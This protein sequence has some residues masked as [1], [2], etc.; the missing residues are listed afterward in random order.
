VEALLL[1]KPQFEVGKGRVGKGGV[2]RDPVA[3]RDAIAAVIAAAGQLDWRPRGL[4]A[5]PITGPA[6]NHEY[7]LWLSTEEA[8]GPAE[9]GSGGV[10]PLEIR[11]LVA[12]TLA[13]S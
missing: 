12:K 10:E 6:G 2:V 7:V 13:T 5:S 4:I 9:G 11:T 1:V 3:H 8:G